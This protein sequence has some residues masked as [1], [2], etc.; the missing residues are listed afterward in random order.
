VEIEETTALISLYQ[1]QIG[2]IEDFLASNANHSY[3]AEIKDSQLSYL[4]HLNEDNTNF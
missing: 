3:L 4:L 1:Q 2:L